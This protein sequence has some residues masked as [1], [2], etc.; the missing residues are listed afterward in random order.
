MPSCF[1][2]LHFY[3]G[4]E[5]NRP[6]V[7][8]AHACLILPSGRPA[9]VAAF[10]T[11]GACGGEARRPKAADADAAPDEAV[12]PLAPSKTFD[13]NAPY[14]PSD[15][16][17]WVLC[18]FRSLRSRCERDGLRTGTTV[19]D[20]NLERLLKTERKTEHKAEAAP[21]S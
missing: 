16:D 9:P 17:S 10:T 21:I 5:A 4:K 1:Y 20:E 15:P 7:I 11:G 3:V 2:G 14:D 18:T 8:E 12:A 6:R 19:L 13:V